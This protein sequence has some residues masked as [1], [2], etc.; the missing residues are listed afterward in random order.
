MTIFAYVLGLRGRLVFGLMAIAAF[1]LLVGLSATVLRASIMASLIL[2]ARSTGR[3][4]AVMRALIFAGL[5]M[6]AINPYLLVF[7]TGFQL[8]FVATAGLIL[9]APHL[10]R[11]VAFVPSTIGIREFLVATLATQ[12]FVMPL[13]LYQIGEFSVVSVLVNVLVLPMVPVA[14]LL[15]FLTGVVGFLSASLALPLA[16]ATHLS[17]S[18]IIVVAEWFAGLPFSSYVV[19]PFPAWFMVL[20]YAALGYGV[21]WWHQ[22][23]KL[24]ALAMHDRDALAGWTIEEV[25][26]EPKTEPAGELRSPAG[27]IRL[28]Y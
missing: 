17:L 27:P 10:E 4:Y 8:S 2:V 22:R 7:D 6:L 26:A 13:L 24:P 12:L 5:I 20:S 9:L 15:T 16:Y 28:F 25:G 18:Y 19:P 3:S 1:A 11:V 23:S 14:M 21:W